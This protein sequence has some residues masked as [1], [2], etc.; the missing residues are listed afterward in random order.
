MNLGETVCLAGWLRTWLTG[1]LL[2]ISVLSF[3]M[4]N[5]RVEESGRVID[6]VGYRGEDVS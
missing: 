2:S 1:R 5:C 4:G 3:T 6:T